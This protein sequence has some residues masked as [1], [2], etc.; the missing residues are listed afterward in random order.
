M[1]QY[2]LIKAENAKSNN[3]TND[4]DENMLVDSQDDD[5][6][7]NHPVIKR[8][9][10]LNQ[11]GDKLQ[12]DVESKVPGLTDQVENLAKASSLMFGDEESDGEDSENSEEEDD[13][14]KIVSSALDQIASDQEEED[15]ESSS[16]EEEED[17]VQV[18]KN[19]RNEARFAVRSQ[20]HTHLSNDEDQRSKK[21]RR[22]L[23]AFADYG[24]EDGADQAILDK[25]NKSLASTV[26][27]ITQRRKKSPSN[28][29]AETEETEN[30]DRFE[31]G[32]E[33][34][35]A[36]LGGDDDEDQK[37]I[38]MDDGG[39]DDDPDGDDFYAQM[40]KKSKEKKE[41]KK[42]MYAV[43][44][45]YPGMDDEV[46]GERSVGQ[47]IMKNRGLVA[48]KSKMNRNPRVKKR[49]QYRKAIIRRKGAVRE[50]RTEEGHKYGGE[51]TGIRS[52]L[53][54]SRK[55]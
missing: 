27:T 11:L 52:G 17:A 51:E 54:R 9:N 16:S 45:K 23:P 15:G 2:L 26:N 49:E 22:A 5:N 35:N 24:D 48:H 33:M 3:D 31:R 42:N 37:D 10:Q 12:S 29:T 44:P 28:G 8:L 25:A 36:D 14:S 40:K 53:S 50:V 47:M 20:D 43:A 30:A 21:R 18:Q 46:H 7:R 38:D 55:L 39:L 13:E 34:M 19:V 41:F 32:L 6:I 1:C 4:D